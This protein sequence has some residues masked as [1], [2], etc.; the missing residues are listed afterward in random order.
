MSTG[1]FP[2]LCCVFEVFHH[3]RIRKCLKSPVEGALGC[4]R[5]HGPRTWPQAGCP[6]HTPDLE[7]QGPCSREGGSKVVE[8]RLRGPGSTPCTSLL[9]YSLE[10]THVPHRNPDNTVTRA[11]LRCQSRGGGGAR[12]REQAWF[13]TSFSFYSSF[14]KESTVSF[15]PPITITYSYPLSLESCFGCICGFD[16]QADL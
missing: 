11:S 3:T 10:V 1:Q 9:F 2:P 15:L 14:L 8:H 13:W 5:W 4:G 6:S 7:A 12:G 16:M